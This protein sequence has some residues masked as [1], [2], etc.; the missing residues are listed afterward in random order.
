MTVDTAQGAAAFDATALWRD[1]F[2]GFEDGARLLDLATGGGQVA[3]L[4]CQAAGASGRRFEVV[5]VDYADLPAAS[6]PQQDGPQLLGGVSLEKLPFEAAKFDGAASQFGI[7]YADTRAAL[8][9]LARVLRP[10]GRAL[11]LM[12]HSK[13][14]V[15]QWTA[16]QAAAFDAVTGQG[17]AMR[18]ARR[19]VTAH[20]KRLPP[21]ELARAE[22]AFR[23]SVRRLAERLEPR[24]EFQPARQFV[25]YLNDLAR[26]ISAYEPRSALAR[27]DDVEAINAAWRQR[28]RSQLRAA[29]DGPGL[30][31]FLRR[32]EQC[33]LVATEQAETHDA[34][35]AVI[36]WRVGLVRT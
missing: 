10:G 25:D 15:T 18:H 26:R 5:G 32:A 4:A 6:G 30:A 14:A 3:R 34:R 24:P 2:A 21:P 16:A 36:G 29:L 22:A 17:G 23:E 33:G 12:H 11:F 28:H 1:F 9:E 20:L 7:E 27:L 8:G 31:S 13:S 35:G 19:A